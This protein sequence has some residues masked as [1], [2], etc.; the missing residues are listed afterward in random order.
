M[1][2]TLQKRGFIQRM[3]GK[4][5]SIQLRLTRAQLPDLA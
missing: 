5:R 3:P 2:V 4:A 1:I